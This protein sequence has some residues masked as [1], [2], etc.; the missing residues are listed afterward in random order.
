MLQIWES[1]CKEFTPE[2]LSKVLRRTVPGFRPIY[3]SL[4]SL[5]IDDVFDKAAQIGV[6]EL[7]DTQTV[8]VGAV[9][10]KG[11]LT[12][13]SGKRKQYDLAKRILRHGD[14]NAGIFAFYDNA[15]RF[16]FSLVTIT[17]HGTKRQ[18]S[19]FRRY[20]FSLIQSC[21]TRPLQQMQRADFRQFQEYWRPFPLKL[22]RMSLQKIQE[23]VRCS[24]CSCTRYHDTTLNKILLLF[25]IRIIFLGFVQKKG[26]LDNNRKFIQN[27]W[28]EYRQSGSTD[29]FYKDWLE[30]L[31]FE[32][33]SSPPGQKVA[34]GHAPFSAKTQKALQMAPY[35]NGELFKRKHG[36]DDLGLWIPDEPIGD[37]FD[38]LFQYNFTV[39]E[40]ELYD[41]ELELNPEFLGIIFER[42]TN[43]DQG[44]VYTP[45]LEV[46]FMCRLA[47]VKWLEQTTDIEKRL[48]PPFLQ[49]SW[50]WRSF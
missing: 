3:N 5:I 41:E 35:L 11:E 27:F 47:L 20:T 15:G 16:R 2:Q 37:F 1:L 7:P 48:V 49:R 45:R 24:C 42:I 25:A 13:R 38:F 33:L 19:T 43:K 8:F 36:V 29:T 50:Y 18:Y 14:F 34:Y 28:E 17:Y 9:H 39:E 4:D 23:Q 26:W 32:A 21:P 40:N 10:V 6:I 30:P 46:D 22:S 12:A 31:F 44:A